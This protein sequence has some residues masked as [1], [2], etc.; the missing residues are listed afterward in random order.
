[1]PWCPW[2][3]QVFF[4]ADSFWEVKMCANCNSYILHVQKGVCDSISRNVL[5]KN[6]E[7]YIENTAKNEPPYSFSV[8]EVLQIILLWMLMSLYAITP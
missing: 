2:V 4:G 3:W 1:M 6:T 7:S 8:L 5:D